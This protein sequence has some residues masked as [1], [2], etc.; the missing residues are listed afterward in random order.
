MNEDL[1]ISKAPRHLRESILFMR[2][3][4]IAARDRERGRSKPKKTETAEEF[5]SKFGVSICGARCALLLSEWLGGLHHLPPGQEHSCVDWSGRFVEIRDRSFNLSTYDFDGLTRLVLL[6]HEHAIRAEIRPNMRS[7]KI[8]L[9]PRNFARDESDM[10]RVYESHLTLEELMEKIAVMISEKNG[11]E[12]KQS[13][14]SG[15]KRDQTTLSE[16]DEGPKR[17]AERILGRP[18]F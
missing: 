18:M 10:G 4:L 3:K 9:F 11:I 12:Q 5:T 13:A 8:M 2:E 1:E 7:V 6:A 17:E 16:D 15:E 14:S